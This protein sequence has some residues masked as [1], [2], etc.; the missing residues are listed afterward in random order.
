M[1]EDAITGT[2]GVGERP[3]LQVADM[4]E[5][6]ASFWKLAGPGAVLVGL[7]IGAGEIIVWPRIAAEYGGSMVWAAVVGVF[8]QLW[9]NFEIARW[10]IATGETAF[11]GFARAWKGFAVVFLGFT[12]FGW[13][14]PDG[15]R[16]PGWH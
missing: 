12:V 9:I 3:P 13:I 16:R 1:Q 10:T 5:R 4:P 8:L 6:T 7:S 15:R 2:E 14:A 11:S